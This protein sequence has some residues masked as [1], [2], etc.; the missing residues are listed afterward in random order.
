MRSITFTNTLLGA[1]FLA[2]AGQAEN[3]PFSCFYRD[4]TD[5]HLAAHPTQIVDEIWMRF[6]EDVYGYQFVDILVRTANQGHAAKDGLGGQLFDQTVHCWDNEG[7]LAC[8]VDCDGGYMEVEAHDGEM[9]QF[10]TQN[11]WVGDTEECGG[12]IDLAEIPGQPVSYRLYATDDLACD[13]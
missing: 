2:S 13:F 10:R 8:A 4:Y 3:I 6:D 12:A 11:L 1:A 5:E 7:V 9:L